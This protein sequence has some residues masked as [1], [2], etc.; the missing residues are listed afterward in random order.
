MTGFAH[1][2]GNRK[3]ECYAELGRLSNFAPQSQQSHT[4]FLV[5]DTHRF[6]FGVGRGLNGASDRWTV[7]GIISF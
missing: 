1:A 7:K 6:N 5:V 4:L 3:R 2:A